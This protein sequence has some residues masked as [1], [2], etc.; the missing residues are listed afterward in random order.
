VSTA[1]EALVVSW[2]KPAWLHGK[3][4]DLAGF[5]CRAVALAKG[6]AMQHCRAVFA[7]AAYRLPCERW[8]EGGD[9]TGKTLKRTAKNAFAGALAF[10]F[11]N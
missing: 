6:L 3:P 5:T 10:A 4:A 2:R 1:S 7:Q 9:Y 11:V 8:R